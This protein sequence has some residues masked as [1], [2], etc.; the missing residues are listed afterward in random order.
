MYASRPFEI[1]GIPC[2]QF[3]NQEPGSNAEILNSLKYVR[4]GNNYIPNFPLMAKSMVNGKSQL[5]LYTWLK[6]RCG[7]PSPNFVSAPNIQWDPVLTTDITWNFEKFLIDKKGEPYKRYDP[8]VP[9]IN[10]QNDI[11]SLISK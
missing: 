1:V 7:A 4:P 5:P 2:G 9:A 10:M 8:D 6:G 3:H 11:L